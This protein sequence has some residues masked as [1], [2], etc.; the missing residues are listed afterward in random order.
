MGAIKKVRTIIFKTVNDNRAI[1]PRLVVGL[2][3]ISEGIQK[4][5]FPESVGSGRFE[6]IGFV[7]PDFWAGLVGAFEIS[8]G[9][10]VL[11]G[12]VLRL[13]TIPLLFIMATALIT[14]KL[15]VLVEKGFW[16]MAHDSRTDFSMTLLL[17]FLFIYGAGKL[18]VDYW[19]SYRH[20]L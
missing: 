12:L 2:V 5:I 10:L 7:N 19:I 9:T 20:K 4:F 16:S 18:S 6:S 3:F 15:P 17:V 1:L 14:T 13:A 11:L 8:C